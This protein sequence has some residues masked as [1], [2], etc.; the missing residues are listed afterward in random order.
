M[1][2]TLHATTV[3]ILISIALIA[4]A[5]CL[6]PVNADDLQPFTTDKCSSWPEGTF[7]KPELWTDCCVAHDIAYWQGGTYSERMAA[8]EA[9]QM[10]VAEQGEAAI[11]YIMEAGVFF[12]GSPFWP[13]SYRWGY[14]WPWTRGYG[15]LNDEEKEVAA[16]LLSEWEALQSSDNLEADA[17][18]LSEKPQANNP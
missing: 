17:P 6:R 11:S 18:G 8:D 2:K 12:G 10:C 4:V 16:Q 3:L 9:L 1:K 13:T 5:V 14:G 7:S 15:E